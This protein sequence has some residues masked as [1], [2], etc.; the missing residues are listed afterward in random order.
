MD[1]CILAAKDKHCRILYSLPLASRGL[2]LLHEFIGQVVDKP[3]HGRMVFMN[4]REGSRGK[5]LATH[6][7][8]DVVFKIPKFIFITAWYWLFALSVNS[9]QTTE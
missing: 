6:I 3:Y 5:E 1:A 8:L 7:R 2:K 4:L 9:A